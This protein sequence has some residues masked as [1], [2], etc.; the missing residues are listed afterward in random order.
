MI[1]KTDI[2]YLNDYIITKREQFHQFPEPGFKEFKT[3]GIIASELKAL[4]YHVIEH[5]ATTGV[6]GILNDQYDDTI[7]LRADID[8]LKMQEEND[9]PYKSQID[10]M[11]H[12]CGHDAHI[13]MLLGAAK[14]IAQHKNTIKGR[15]KLLFQPAEEGPL[16]GGAIQVI[17]EGH[18]DDVNA[19][20][21][22]HI[23]TMYETGTLHLKPGKA[24]AS[25]DEFSVTISGFGTHASAPESGNDLVFIAS[26]I[27]Q[28]IHGIVAREVAATDQAVLSVSTIH[29]GTAFNVLP[30]EVKFS[31]TIRTF[32]ETTRSHIHRRVKTITKGIAK[33][34]NI[35]CDINIVKGYPALINDVKMTKFVE[36]IAK[37]SLGDSN[38]IIDTKPSMGG[39]D[40]AYYLNKQKGTFS[41]LGGRHK[42]TEKTYYN[43]NPKFD[44]DPDSLLY[45]TLLHINTV[46]SYFNKENQ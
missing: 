12:A 1:K 2:S 46:L 3:S 17:K 6:I 27:I 21:G 24:M 32:D 30:D 38:V 11:M 22:L 28:A 44:I 19:V 18:L 29:G 39:E 45:G 9:V 23:T 34:H 8:A 26:Q 41:W 13:A 20:F 4:G 14:Y 10:G 37:Q 15:I 25:P 40:F 33:M 36:N 35:T 5:V 16:P 7:L 42:N 43:H 31:G